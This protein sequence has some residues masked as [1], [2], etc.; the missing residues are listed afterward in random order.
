[1]ISNDLATIQCKDTLRAE[2]AQAMARFKGEVTVIEAP[3]VRL[4]T[5][6]DWRRT[7]SLAGSASAS[8]LDRQEALMVSTMRDLAAK[9]IG[10]TGGGRTSGAIEV[11]ACLVAKGQ[12]C[13][14]EVESFVVHGTQDPCVSDKAFALGRN[15]GQENAV[16]AI[17]AGALRTNPLSGPDGVGVQ[18]DHAYTLEARAEVQAVCT[19]QYGETAVTLTA[20]HDSS[21]CADRGQNVLATG[22]AVRRL[23]PRETERLQG[24]KDGYTLIP[25]RGKHA[26]ECPDGPRYKAIGNSKAVPVVR[27]IGQRIQQQL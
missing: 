19:T 26:D 23:T 16:F 4:E 9:G 10:P 8:N 24:F 2:L 3:V 21:P 5:P 27:W 11:A 7:L 15:S 6:G 17:Q 18:A 25:W 20:R 12:K 13:D 14:F 22:S 1:M